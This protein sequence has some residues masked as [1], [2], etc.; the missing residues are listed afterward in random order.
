MRH[1]QRGGSTRDPDAKH[2]AMVM[3]LL[4]GLLAL[5][6]RLVPS[7]QLLLRRYSVVVIRLSHLTKKYG[8]FTAVDDLCVDVR[9]G[10]VLGLLGPNGAGKTTTM[11]MVTGFLP[12]SKGR[13]SVAGFD[14]YDHPIQAKQKIGYLPEQP[15]ALPG[16]DRAPLSGVRGGPERRAGRQDEG[17]R[18]SGDRTGARRR[19][20]RYAHQHALEGLSPAGRP[21]AGDRARAAGVGARRADVEPR[22]AAAQRRAAAHPRSQ[23]PAHDHPLDAHPP[24]SQRCRR[25]RRHHQPRESD[26]GGHAGEPRRTPAGGRIGEARDR[27]GSGADSR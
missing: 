22:P 18:L 23:G 21:R 10:E 9:E 2:G 14:L 6:Q 3:D 8:A 12:P 4:Q 5:A 7:P 24:R 27:R 25:P 19:R 16:D 11:R 26:G 1:G 15:P 17:R 13:V 20:G